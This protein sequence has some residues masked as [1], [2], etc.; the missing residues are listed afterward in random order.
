LQS[1]VKS[2]LLKDFG[3]SARRLKEDTRNFKAFE[4]EKA[5]S[6]I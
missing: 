5:S 3:K 4:R 1:K 2:S 6:E